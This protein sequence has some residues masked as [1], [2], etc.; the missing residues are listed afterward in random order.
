MGLGWGFEE[1]ERG[2]GRREERKNEGGRE[3][4]EGREDFVYILFLIFDE[5]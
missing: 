4:G 1:R 3:E 5:I 2:V